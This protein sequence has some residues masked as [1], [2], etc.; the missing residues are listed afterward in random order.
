MQRLQAHIH[1]GSVAP[2]RPVHE[3]HLRRRILPVLADVR[4][5]H[6]ADL[7]KAG[8]LPAQVL[9]VA[10]V[11]E[12]IVL[13]DDPPH[14]VRGDVVHPLARRRVGGDKIQTAANDRLIA[15]HGLDAG[16][17]RVQIAH[18]H[19]AVALDAVPDILLHV[20]VDGVGGDIPY[21]LEQ[22]VAAMEA[23]QI[24]HVQIDKHGF[25]RLQRHSDVFRE[26]VYAHE[27][28]ARLAD[29]VHAQ[30]VYIYLQ[31]APRVVVGGVGGAAQLA[32]GLGGGFAKADA[33][34]RPLRARDLLHGKLYAA[35]QFL[36]EIQQEGGACAAVFERAA[37]VAVQRDLPGL[38]LQ[39]CGAA[40]DGAVLPLAFPEN[41]PGRY[42]QPRALVPFRA[43]FP[44]QLFEKIAAVARVLP[45]IF[46]FFTP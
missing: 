38:I 13:G 35:V 8:D 10:K 42:V 17:L 34:F 9:A 5:E 18:P 28:K 12:M 15:E 43:P 40:D 14:G 32:H 16:D 23:A 46:H 37:G 6:A 22:R 1:G 25:G 4:R 36:P 31:I 41:A 45:S 24:G 33:Q 11:H 7:R 44:A 29:G 21:A 39:K 3:A 27:A 20:E 2:G 26:Q 30:R 19:E